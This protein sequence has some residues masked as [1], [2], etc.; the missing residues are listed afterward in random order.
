MMTEKNNKKRE[1]DLG[2]D[3]DVAVKVNGVRVEVSANGSVIAYTS[4][5]VK[6]VGASNDDKKPAPAPGIGDVMPDGTIYAGLSPD[7]GE[8]LYAT[9]QDAPLRMKWEKAVK[10]AADLDAYGHKD[11]RLP[12]LRELKALYDSRHKGALKGIFNDN[13]GSSWYW[14]CRRG[15]P[16][17]S[18]NVY[19]VHFSDGGDA[20]TGKGNY[21]LSVRPVRAE[22]RP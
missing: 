16:D 18:S 12:T 15:H 1:I 13:T 3:F 14:S 22:R 6:V 2:N 5:S 17:D 8:A 20:W 11:W 10:Y 7:T 9:P 19:Y 4:G 21:E